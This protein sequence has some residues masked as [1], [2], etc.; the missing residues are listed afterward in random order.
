VKKHSE[1][2]LACSYLAL[3]SKAAQLSLKKRHAAKEEEMAENL[4]TEMAVKK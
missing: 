3:I 2:R 1:R 4:T